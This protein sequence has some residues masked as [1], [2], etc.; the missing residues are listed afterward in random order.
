MLLTVRV[1]GALPRPFYSPQ[2]RRAIK[3]AADESRHRDATKG[4]TRTS[5]EYYRRTPKLPLTTTAADDR[6]DLGQARRVLVRLDVEVVPDAR[7]EELLHGVHGL[8]L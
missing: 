7:Q 5:E 8:Q 4:S 6:P 1:K 2:T 3:D